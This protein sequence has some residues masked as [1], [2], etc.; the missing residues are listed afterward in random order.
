M[1][2]DHEHESFIKTPKQL[3]IVVV[4]SFAIPILV[5]VLASQLVTSGRRIPDSEA[6]EQLAHLIAP[7]AKVELGTLST[8]GAAAKTGE[9]VYQGAC[10][11][12]HA[13]GA[14][15]APKVGDTAAWG[16][17]IANGLDALV[18][19]AIA[20]K[21]AMPPK[22]GNAALSD[23]E[24]ARGIVYMANQSGANFKEPAVTPTAAQAEASASAL[25]RAA[26]PAAAITPGGGPAGSS[27][28]ADGKA[29]YGS[30]CALC[31][32]AGIGGAPKTGDAGA[33]GPRIAQGKDTLVKNALNGKAAMP[34]KG[35]NPALSEADIRAAVDYLVAQVK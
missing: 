7:V 15:G 28:Q 18:K 31:H 30:V 27:A 12:C 22:G 34:P 21:G 5:A 11:A 3:I 1:S 29:I 14:A 32:A 6:S 19:S 35:G 8:A 9:Q 25:P 10:Q 2:T 20:G 26:A 17:R 23:I 24:I 4:L 33:W 13:S 16:P